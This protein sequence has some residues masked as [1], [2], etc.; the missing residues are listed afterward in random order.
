MTQ[1][2]PAYIPFAEISRLPIEYEWNSWDPYT[3]LGN[4]E[5]ATLDALAEVSDRGVITF[6][7]GCSEWV[8]FRLF[9]HF[10]DRR[11]LQYLEACWA[12]VMG[13]SIAL[14]PELKESEWQG[15]ILSPIGLSIQTIINSWKMAEDGEA[16]A[17]A[18]FAERLPLL[19][20]NDTASFII[21][22]NEV[23]KRLIRFHPYDDNEPIGKL[24]AREI[25]DPKINLDGVNQNDLVK[26]ALEA[27]SLKENPYIELLEDGR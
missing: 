12:L 20:L 27:M 24:V 13:A 9:P 1:S 17:H 14:P 15:K 21:W 8:V 2:A 25:L 23:L 22:R 6:A 26:R 11:A 7:I 5:E 3:L 19:V 18:G 4:A 10:Q 16:D